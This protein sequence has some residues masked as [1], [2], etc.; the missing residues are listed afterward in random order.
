MGSLE[1]GNEIWWHFMAGESIRSYRA[2]VDVYV[3]G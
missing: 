2:I 1:R 3:L